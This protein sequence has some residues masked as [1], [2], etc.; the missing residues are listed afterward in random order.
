MALDGTRLD[1]F[2]RPNLGLV[3]RN[4]TGVTPNDSPPTDQSRAGNTGSGC[5]GLYV[6]MEGWVRVI[7]RA[8]QFSLTAGAHHDIDWL[9][10]GHLVMVSLAGVLHPLQWLPAVPVSERIWATDGTYLWGEM[11]HVMAHDTTVPPGA[12]HALHI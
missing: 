6:A 5:I 8:N 10:L 11:V 12:I 2:S 7:F 1:N 4:W 9:G 3:A